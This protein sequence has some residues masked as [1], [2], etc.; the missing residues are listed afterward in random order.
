MI[1]FIPPKS[2]RGN[3]RWRWEI[4]Y[5][6]LDKYCEKYDMIKDEF[7]DLINDKKIMSDAIER[8]GGEYDL[9]IWAEDEI[10]TV[11]II[12]CVMRKNSQKYEIDNRNRTFSNNVPERVRELLYPKNAVDYISSVSYECNG[13][14]KINERAESG[15]FFQPLGTP[16]DGKMNKRMEK[17]LEQTAKILKGLRNYKI[18]PELILMPAD[19]YAT[20]I[21]NWNKE[22]AA[23]F[24]SE[25]SDRV[26]T[27]GN[28][29][30][31][32]VVPYSQIIKENQGL[33]GKIKS[34]IIKR[35]IDIDSEKL[36]RAQTYAVDKDPAKAASEYVSERLIEGILIEEKFKPIKVSLASPDKDEF[37]GP[38][39]RVYFR[40]TPRFPWIQSK[41][42]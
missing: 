11:P 24:I 34:Y 40:K 21:D 8:G 19:E 3:K 16:I 23:G 38:L 17:A 37:D 2:E 1:Y 35:Q 7:F 4:G 5:A 31:I 39:P 14:E 10:R 41:W 27:M 33:Y 32:E 22:I 20:R 30:K 36:Y 28:D 29:V 26:N 15:V 9:E 25:L 12:S 13:I 18:Q 42:D 6:A